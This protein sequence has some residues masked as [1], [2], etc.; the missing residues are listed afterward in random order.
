VFQLRGLIKAGKEK[1]GY[2]DVRALDS[3]EEPKAGSAA[4]NKMTPAR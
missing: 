1:E 2:V 4:P 3:E